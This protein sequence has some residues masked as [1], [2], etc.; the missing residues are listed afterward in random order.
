MEYGHRIRHTEGRLLGFSYVDAMV[1]ASACLRG[2]HP[3][4]QGG[5]TSQTC[6]GYDHGIIMFTDESWRGSGY[7]SRPSV[8]LILVL[9]YGHGYCNTKFPLLC[10][11]ST[12]HCGYIYIFV[13]QLETEAEARGERQAGEHD[14]RS[15]INLFHLLT[16]VTIVDP[17]RHQTGMQ[18]RPVNAIS[19]SRNLSSQLSM[20]V[21][22]FTHI[23]FNFIVLVLYMTYICYNVWAR[24][25]FASQ[26]LQNPDE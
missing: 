18:Q 24:T 23:A 19:L 7:L 25:F 6:T 21:F 22:S 2:I 1:L 16:I 8:Y 5:N 4:V 15:K 17:F 3:L 12:L 9:W 10:F 13:L 20:A 11:R 14:E 26:N